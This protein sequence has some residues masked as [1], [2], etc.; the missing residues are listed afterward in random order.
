MLIISYTMIST[1]GRLLAREILDSLFPRGSGTGKNITNR[2]MRG[3]TGIAAVATD[4]QS[5]MILVGWI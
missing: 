2:G 1:Q 3:I 4:I 5:L